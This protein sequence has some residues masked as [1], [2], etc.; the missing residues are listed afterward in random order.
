MTYVKYGTAY[1]RIFAIGIGTT[2]MGS[3]SMRQRL[4]S[5][6]N[7]AWQEGIW[8]QGAG[9]GSMNGKLFRGNNR[10]KENSG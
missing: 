2:T 8:S 6:L 3:Y 4:G 10:V 7:R 9:W 1:F 5:T